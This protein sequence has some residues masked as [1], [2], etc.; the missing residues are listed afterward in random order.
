MIV[1]QLLD[2]F[3]ETIVFETSLCKL[4]YQI[5]IN[6]INFTLIRFYCSKLCNFCVQSCLK[7][8]NQ[9]QNKPIVLTENKIRFFSL[10]KS[11]EDVS[12][13]DEEFTREEPALTP[14]K[15]YRPIA[16]EDQI[17]FNDFDF[18]SDWC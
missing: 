17:K 1:L 5:V 8:E 4:T 18:V 3:K 11:P 2:K 14:P 9:D 10:Q 12:N 16:E 7:R 13:F 15:D 6:C